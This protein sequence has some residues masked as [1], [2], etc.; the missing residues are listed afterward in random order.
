[1]QVAR[2]AAVSVVGLAA[3]RGDRE[4]RARR[5]ERGGDQRPG[6]GRALQLER[7]HAGRVDQGA[8]CFVGQNTCEQAGQGHACQPTV[9]SGG[10]PHETPSTQRNVHSGVYAWVGAVRGVGHGAGHGLF[11]PVPGGNAPSSVA[12]P[13]LRVDVVANG[14]SHGWDVG[15]LPG[16]ALLVPQRPGRLALVRDGKVTDVEADF[17]DLAVRGEGGLTGMVVH[18]DFTTSRRFTT[19]QQHRLRHP[20]R[21]VGAG[22][23]QRQAGRRT[24]CSRVFRSTRA[25]G[26]PAAG[27]RWR[28]TARFSSAPATPRTAR[29]PQDRT[30]LGGKVLRIDLEHRRGVP[31]NPFASSSNANERRIFTYGHRNVQ[32]V[33]LRPGTGQV[34]TAEHGPT[35]DDEVNL[36]HTG[37]QLRL[38]PVRGAARSAGTTRTCR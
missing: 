17:S 31:G 16:G 34:F 14:L 24:R 6:G 30:S 32:G 21:H 2:A 27:R 4:Y 18:P 36:A 25:A 5:G 1:M 15:F 20:P 22:R 28:R 29:I 19:C 26:T 11:R 9:C 12:A 38:G 10:S 23:H 7:G 8:Q 33:V 35:I 37:R 13:R 3:G